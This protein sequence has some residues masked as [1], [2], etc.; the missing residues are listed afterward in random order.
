MIPLFTEFETTDQSGL[1]ERKREALEHI[2]SAWS[3]AN[4]AGI[5]PEVVASMAIYAA[6]ADLAETMGTEALAEL[7]AEL[8]QRIRHGEFSVPRTLQ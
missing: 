2:L 3:E 5:E 8:P 4:E 7:V 1:E 6:L